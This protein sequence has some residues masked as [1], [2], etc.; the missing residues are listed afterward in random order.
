MS[1]FFLKYFLNIYSKKKKNQRKIFKFSVV[2]KRA[3]EKFIY[4]HC[5]C[6]TTFQLLQRL[7]STRKFRLK[8]K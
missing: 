8:K 4:R 6:S 2:F 1:A 5:T 3:V 7:D